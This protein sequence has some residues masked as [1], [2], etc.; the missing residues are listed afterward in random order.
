LLQYLMIGPVLMI[1][2]VM[3]SS[4]EIDPDS[5]ALKG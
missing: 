4:E 5:A 2:L 3:S 1:G